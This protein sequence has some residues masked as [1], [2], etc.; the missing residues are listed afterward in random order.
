MEGD[1]GSSHI[2]KLNILIRLIG[3]IFCAVHHFG[4]LFTIS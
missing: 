2:G 3:H 4:T 1:S